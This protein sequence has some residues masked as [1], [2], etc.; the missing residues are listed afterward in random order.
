MD[1]RTNRIFGT[2][3]AVCLAFTAAV[4]CD[5]ASDFS[6]DDTVPAGA[7]VNVSLDMTVSP[8]LEMTDAGTRGMAINGTSSVEYATVKNLWILQFAGTADTCR[9]IGNP[10]YIEEYNSTDVIKLI[11]SSVDNRLIFVANTFARTIAFGDCSTLADAKNMIRAVSLEKDVVRADTVS[12][13]V[14]HYPIMNGYQDVTVQSGITISSQL[15]HSVARVDVQIVNATTG[16]GAVTLESVR[17][18]SVADRFNYITDY[19]LPDLYPTAAA[20]ETFDYTPTAWTAGETVSEN[21]DNR[22][23]TFY[24]PA[25]K[26]GT[27]TEDTQ[28]GKYKG[29]FAPDKATYLLV[30]GSFMED[31]IQRSVTYTFYLG[32]NLITDFNVVPNGHYS[33]T[34]TIN[35]KGD[36][37]SDGRV[38]DNGTVNFCSRELANSYIINPPKATGSWKNFRIPVKRVYD[39]W[40]ADTRYEDD[41]SY[42]LDEN[43]EGW[44]VDVIWS[45]FPI[46]DNTFKWVKKN[47]IKSE[48]LHPDSDYFEFSIKNGVQ[49]N[50]VIG[51]RRYLNSALQVDGMNNFLWSWHMWVTDYQ[52]DKAAMYAATAGRYVY[53]VPGGSVHRYDNAIFNSGIYKDKFIMDRNLGA[54]DIYYHGTS[55]SKDTDGMLYYQFGRKDPFAGERYLYFLNAEGTYEKKKWTQAENTITNTD[56]NANCY[57]VPYS[58][59]NP[60]TFI[61][62][63]YWTYND[64]YNP[65]T[66]NSNIRW[67]DPYVTTDDGKSIFDPCPPG[68]KVPKN[69]TWDGFN[70]SVSSQYTKFL[71]NDPLSSGRNYFPNTYSDRSTG[72]IFYPASGALDSG[73]GAFSGVGSTGRYWSCSPG[74]ASL[75]YYLSFNS[76]Y[77]NPSDNG[78]R[79]SGFPVRCVQE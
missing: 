21:S 74:S 18:M 52:P 49:G 24:V 11:A 22:K 60:M 14:T 3:V 78:S 27:I 67:Q 56:A 61:K 13:V 44:V 4:S 41:N 32:A 59:H 16:A 51:I 47:R 57:N 1:M 69:G 20:F 40:K 8:L 17:M 54:Q 71:W 39:F 50:F 62:G 76:G 58:I 72:T 5:D 63:S 36:M 45:E 75:G 15:K 9:R 46:N 28:S 65:T 53:S 66:Y 33:Y 34:F 26:R 68:W 35:H 73:S 2:V 64:I 48:G 38:D 23:F 10:L 42:N 31:T 37:D 77:V 79:A 19:T 12:G 43:S 55:D 70:A 30:T 6:G 25:N 29:L 7:P